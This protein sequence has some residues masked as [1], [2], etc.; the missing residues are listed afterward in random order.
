MPIED[1]KL[2]LLSDKPEESKQYHT[3]SSS[4]NSLHSK[5]IK[6]KIYTMLPKTLNILNNKFILNGN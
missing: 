1:L 5:S 6:E 3:Y 4:E 2:Y